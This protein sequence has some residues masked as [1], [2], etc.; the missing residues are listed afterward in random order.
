VS[1]APAILAALA[2]AEALADEVCRLRT[3]LQH[4]ATLAGVNATSPTGTPASAL[5]ASFAVVNRIATAALEQT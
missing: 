4:I 5:A 3:V 1:A 2:E